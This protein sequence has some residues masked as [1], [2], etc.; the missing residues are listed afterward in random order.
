VTRALAH[1]EL[2]S[3]GR[4]ALTRMRLKYILIR[5]VSEHNERISV[6]HARVSAVPF[7]Y[8]EVSSNSSWQKHRSKWE[9]WTNLKVGESL[10]SQTSFLGVVRITLN[11][12]NTTWYGSWSRRQLVSCLSG[13]ISISGIR[14][15]LTISPCAHGSG[16]GSMTRELGCAREPVRQASQTE[17]RRHNVWRVRLL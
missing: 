8:S 5:N 3:N 12:T 14:A 10:T 1:I 15:G 11:W 17:S 16:V 2:I 4:C 6:L 9:G 13:E 7:S